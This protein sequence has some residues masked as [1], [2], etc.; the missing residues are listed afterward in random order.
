M[1]FKILISQ[2]GTYPPGTQLWCEC[3]GQAGGTSFYTFS[4]VTS[5]SKHWTRVGCVAALDADRYTPGPMEYLFL[6]VRLGLA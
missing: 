3:I 6:L 4:Q 2:P 5:H 1:Q